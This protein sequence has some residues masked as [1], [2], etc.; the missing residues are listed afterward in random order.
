MKRSIKRRGLLALVIVACIALAIHV[1]TLLSSPVTKNVDNYVYD[2][3]YAKGKSFK[4]VQGYGGLFS[5]KNAAALDFSMPVG[6]PIYAARSGVVF[7][8]KE[9][10]DQGGPFPELKSKANYIMIQH[11]DGSLGCYW[12]LKKD[13]VLVESGPVVQ[14]QLIAYSGYTGFTLLPHLHFSVKKKLNYTKDAFVRTRFL[15]TNG[16]LLLANKQTYTRPVD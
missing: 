10:S 1:F 9:D 4:V 11:S 2:L 12:H 3:P 5:H 8:F 7:R 13:G 15:T 14:G 16:V 6:T